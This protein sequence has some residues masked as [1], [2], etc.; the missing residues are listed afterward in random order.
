MPVEGRMPSNFDHLVFQYQHRFEVRLLVMCS[1]SR[2]ARAEEHHKG[3]AG[4]TNVV[5]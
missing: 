5:P 1:P 3:P 2:L 4:P